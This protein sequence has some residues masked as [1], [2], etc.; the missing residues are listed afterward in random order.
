[1]RTVSFFCIFAIKCFNQPHKKLTEHK[2]FAEKPI[3]NDFSS[4]EL[5]KKRTLTLMIDT[6]THSQRRP[7]SVVNC[8][9]REH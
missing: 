9:K 5:F 7:L 6:N 8:L 4:N 1:M 2:A 3:G